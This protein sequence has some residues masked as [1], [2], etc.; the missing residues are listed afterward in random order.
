MI[1]SK[2]CHPGSIDIAL[3]NSINLHVSTHSCDAWMYIII[4][5]IINIST[6]PLICVPDL[7]ITV[8]N[9]FTNV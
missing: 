4:M 1:S 8:I 3:I 6:Y 7:S 5:L 2:P 9:S